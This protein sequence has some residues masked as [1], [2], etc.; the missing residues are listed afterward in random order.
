M[1]NDKPPLHHQTVESSDNSHQMGWQFDNTYQQLSSSFYSPVMPTAVKAPAMVLFNEPLAAALGLNPLLLNTSA[2]AAI[3][4]GNQLPPGA[5]PIA[6]A[7]AGH[8]FG[9]FTWLGDGR[10]LLLGEQIAPNGDRFDI[11]LKGSGPTPYSRQGDGRAALGPMLREYLISEAMNALGIPTS[12]SLAVVIT[13]EPVF[14]ETRLQGAVL[15]RVAASHLRVGT[16]QYAAARLTLDDVRQLADYAIQRHYPE[17]EASENPYLLLLQSAV[18]RQASLVAQ[19]MLVGFIHGVMNTDNMTI[20]GETID[21]GPCAFVDTYHPR[22]VF[23]SIDHGGRYAYGNQPSIAGWNLA[24]FAETLLPLLHP[25]KEKGIQAAQEALDSFTSYFQQQW[26]QGMRRKLGLFTEET[27]DEKLVSQLL[28]LME[29]HQADYTHTFVA[30]TF[31]SSIGGDLMN[32]PAFAEWMAAWEARRSRQ[33]QSI[34]QSHAL[35]QASNPAVIPRNHH[36]EKALRAAVEGNDFQLFH[37]FLEALSRPYA[38]TATQE[39]FADAP[40]PSFKRY[41]TFCGT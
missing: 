3:F 34:T 4:S 15:T 37:R 14:R 21:Y 24:R 26:L 20:S 9:H 27:D 11:Q 17:V 2:G 16:F 29:T 39:E 13:G 22:T 36:V 41:R 33:P 30:L 28:S 25:E 18:R 8:Q 35:M 1:L 38:H 23:S 12:R 19:W 10:A 5:M 7:Y 6:Q 31:N 32:Q 40:P